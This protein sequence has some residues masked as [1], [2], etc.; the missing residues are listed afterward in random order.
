MNPRIAAGTAK[1]G[2][3]LLLQRQTSPVSRVARQSK[4]RFPCEPDDIIFASCA[5]SNECCSA[6]A[7]TSTSFLTAGDDQVHVNVGTRV[8]FVAEVEHGCS[9]DDADAGGGDEVD[10][11]RSL[12]RAAFEHGFHGE[13]QE[14]RMRR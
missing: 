13:A 8:F 5:S 2:R 9:V 6:V 10:Y 4:N 1:N 7:C 3:L 12:E 14:L 11:G